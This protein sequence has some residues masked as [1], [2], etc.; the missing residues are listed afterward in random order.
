MSHTKKTPEIAAGK[1][2]EG[3][4]EF[5]SRGNSVWRWKNAGADS[6]SIVLKRLD[7]DALQLEPTQSVPLPARGEPRDKRISRPRQR[8]DGD[9]RSVNGELSIEKTR[10]VKMG[11]FNP[12]DHS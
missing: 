11:G 7:N 8:V 1:E 5:D 12:Y 10:S 6:T 9:A 2:S 4:V 3:H